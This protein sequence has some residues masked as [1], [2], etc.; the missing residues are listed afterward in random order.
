[1]HQQEWNFWRARN[2]RE[3]TS[4]KWEVFQQLQVQQ[5][6]S[7]F[8]WLHEEWHYMQLYTFEIINNFFA[9]CPQLESPPK[10]FEIQ[11]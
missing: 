7:L 11:V 1:M 8:M 3:N 9:P 10:I 2:I 6:M 4:T 5:Q